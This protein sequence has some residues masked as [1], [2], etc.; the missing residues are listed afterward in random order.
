MPFDSPGPTRAELARELLRYKMMEYSQDGFYASWLHDLEYEL[1]KAADWPSPS[2]KQAE[3]IVPTSRE[4]RTLAEIAGGWWVYEDET[5]PDERGPVFIPMARWLQ[6][7]SD[8]DKN[9]SP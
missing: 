3:H 6:V 8:R 7:L 9:P 1:W 4:C 2:D 5:R